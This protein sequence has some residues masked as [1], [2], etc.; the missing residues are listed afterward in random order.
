MNKLFSIISLAIVLIT[1]TAC[2]ATKLPA[3]KP[4]YVVVDAV[5]AKELL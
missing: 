3:Q 5:A 2:A 4:R 1:L